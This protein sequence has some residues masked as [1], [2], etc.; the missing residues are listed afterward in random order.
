MIKQYLRW[1]DENEQVF[2]QLP[3]REEWREIKNYPNY[4]VSSFGRVRSYVYNRW[5]VRDTASILTLKKHTR[6]Y[7]QIQL[8]RNSKPILVHR[9]VAESFIPNPNN[10]PCVLHDDNNRSNNHVSNLRWG[11]QSENISQGVRDG[12][13]DTQRARAARLE[14]CVSFVLQ[15]KTGEVRVVKNLSQFASDINTSNGNLYSVVKHQRKTAA[16]WG[17]LASPVVL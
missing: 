2:Q 16:G 17:L 4:E 14:A 8:G 11:T 12:N 6:G 13:V 10:L 15:H 3:L 9:L 5:G 1:L 7:R